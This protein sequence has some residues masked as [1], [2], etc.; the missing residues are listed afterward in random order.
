MGLTLKNQKIE[1]SNLCE[2]LGDKILPETKKCIKCGE[3]KTLDNFGFRSAGK[4]GN[5]REQRNDCKSCIIKQVK[6]AKNLKLQYPFPADPN[7]TCPICERTEF[8]IKSNGSFH[9]KQGKKSI[10][11]IDH[12]HITG[13]F[14]GWICDYCNNGLSRFNENPIA[15]RNAAKYLGE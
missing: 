14:R 15:L 13:K 11:R 4:T 7:Y 3:Y 1:M 5:K 10:W 12:N 8:E 6:I 9:E 2:F